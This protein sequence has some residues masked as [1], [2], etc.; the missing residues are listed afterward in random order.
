MIPLMPQDAGAPLESAADGLSLTAKD[1]RDTAASMQG[2]S[3][4]ALAT[5]TGVSAMEEDIASSIRS[6]NETNARIDGIHAT[7]RLG[8]LLGTILSVLMFGLNGLSFYRQLRQ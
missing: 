1:I 3:D 2:V 7:V 5:M 6:L 8:L 4:N